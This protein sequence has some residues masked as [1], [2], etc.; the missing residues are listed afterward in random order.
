ME[1]L[2]PFVRSRAYADYIFE[3]QITRNIFRLTR[4]ISDPSEQRLID[5]LAIHVHEESINGEALHQMLRA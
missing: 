5:M 3:Q 4:T 2:A 1:S